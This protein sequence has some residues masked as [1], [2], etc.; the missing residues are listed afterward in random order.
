[1]IWTATTA[2]KDVGDAIK[3]MYLRFKA[4]KLAETLSRKATI[5][6]VEEFVENFK[7]KYNNKYG[8][9]KLTT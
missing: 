9:A 8:F 4:K 7:K 2:F 5:K 6:D 3:S 1:M